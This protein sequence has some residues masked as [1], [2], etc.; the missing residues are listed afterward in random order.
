VDSL[1][2]VEQGTSRKKS[3]EIIKGPTTVKKTLLILSIIGG[4]ASANAATYTLSDTAIDDRLYLGFFSEASGIKN[5]VLINLGT[6]ADVLSGFT[7][8]FSSVS[9]ALSTAYGANW[10]NNS[11]VFW[12]LIGYDG[13]YGEGGSAYASRQSGS[14][15]L[16]SAGG[17]Y[18]DEEGYY[19][20]LGNVQS[21]IPAQIPG[22]ATLSTIVGSSGNTHGVSVVENNDSTTFNGVADAKFGAFTAV[23]YGQVLNGLNIQQFTLDGSLYKTA[24]DGTFAVITQQNGIITVVPEPTTYALLGLGALML[25]LVYRR[26]VS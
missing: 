1:F 2:R 26:R 25:I 13:A 5:S 22:A 12:G 24:F 20:V 23:P 17:T 9:S 14:A 7:L 21:L 4:F 11:E 3:Q 18:L 16:R 8:D 6:S 10:F 19:S 15:L